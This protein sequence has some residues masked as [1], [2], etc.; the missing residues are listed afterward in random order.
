MENEPDVSLLKSDAQ[1]ASI[2]D[3]RILLHAIVVVGVIALIANHFSSVYPVRPAL[4]QHMAGSWKVCESA[5]IWRT[6]TTW[7]ADESPSTMK[8][9]P[10]IAWDVLKLFQ[11]QEAYNMFNDQAYIT[12][13]L[14][15]II[16]QQLN[17]ESSETHPKRKVLD[18]Y[19]KTERPVFD[20][21]DSEDEN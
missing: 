13:G 3:P 15:K 19:A 10:S 8:E 11:Q 18:R 6:R 12:G 7:I 20:D 1:V 9:S 2:E 16:T 17:A 4:V 21:S 14:K 5:H